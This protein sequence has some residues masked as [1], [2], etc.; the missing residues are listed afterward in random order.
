[1]LPAGIIRGLSLLLPVLLVWLAWIK[2]RPDRRLAGAVLVAFVWQLPAL[3]LVQELNLRA[4]WWHFEADGG[5]LREMPADLWLGWAVLWGAVPAIGLRNLPLWLSAL[6]MVLLDFALM[7]LCAPVVQLY[8]N[9][10]TGDAVAAAIALVP[11]L[12]FARWT[13]ANTQL[14]ARVVLQFLAFSGL[15]LWVIPEII[16]SQTGGSWQ[17]AL[18]RHWA[19]QTVFLSIIA[20]FSV[21]ALSAVQEFCQRGK[22]TPVPLD[23][24]RRLVTSGPYAYMANPMQTG[25]TLVFLTWGLWIGSLWVALVAVLTITAGAGILGWNENRDLRERFGEAWNEYR[26][27]V[28]TWL[29]RLRPRIV[30]PARLYV[31]ES[32]TQCRSLGVWLARRS[33]TGMEILSAENHP[34]RKLTRLTYEA[35]GWSETGLAAFTRALEHINLGWAWI[36]WTLRLPVLR[37]VLQWLV[38]L[39]GGGPRKILEK[40]QWITPRN[41]P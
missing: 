4:G 9:W 18:S 7:P 33:L 13:A 20:F 34:S 36:G 6:V 40:K 17:T 19:C 26:R 29:P 2:A 39:A 32:C 8:D 11:G 28:K 1:M 35:P 14:K 38:D 21:P 12:L 37:P 31:A 10:W 15:M 22:G 30:V 3:L 16:L 5:L 41:R 25:M 27:E 23:P 24:P